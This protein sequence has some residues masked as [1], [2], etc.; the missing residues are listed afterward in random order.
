MRFNSPTST[1]LCACPR[2][3]TGAM[4]VS[5]KMRKRRET[6]NYYSIRRQRRRAARF[7]QSFP[8][9]ALDGYSPEA[10]RPPHP[11]PKADNRAAISSFLYFERDTH[12]PS[13]R[14]CN[15]VAAL[16][17]RHPTGGWGRAGDYAKV[18][19]GHDTR[20]P[21]MQMR[22]ITA[23]FNPQTLCLPYRFKGVAPHLLPERVREE[24]GICEGLPVRHCPPRTRRAPS[25]RGS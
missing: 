14:F 17:D 7:Q 1:L 15:D 23:C 13:E 18:F 21:R 11:S 20:M 2:M 4:G 24:C 10:L 22:N 9:M 3:N 19:L 6:G 8:C 25:C 5:F 16:R 12:G